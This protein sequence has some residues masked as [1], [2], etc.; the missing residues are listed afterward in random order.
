MSEDLT[1]HSVGTHTHHR[2]LLAVLLHLSRR[3]FDAKNQLLKL[4]GRDKL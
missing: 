1:S 4:F 2:V 3:H